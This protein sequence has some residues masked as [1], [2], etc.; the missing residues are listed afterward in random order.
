MIHDILDSQCLNVFLLLERQCEL[1]D[2]CMFLSYLHNHMHFLLIIRFYCIQGAREGIVKMHLQSAA[3]A[4]VQPHA[5]LANS[6]L[7]HSG[8]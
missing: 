5:F 3:M 4:Y 7:L 1:G 2:G 8:S 6:F